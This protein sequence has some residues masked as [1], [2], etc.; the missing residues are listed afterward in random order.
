LEDLWQFNEECVARA[1]AA[2]ELPIITGIGHE[3]DTSI[4]DLV[5]DYH[6]HTPTE[7]ASIAVRHWLR[8]TELIGAGSMRL[9]GA[10]RSVL[11]EARQRLVSIERHEVFRRPTHRIESYRQFMDDRER[12]LDAALADRLR[13]A[14][15]RIE[16]MRARLAGCHPKHRLALNAQRLTD[17]ERRLNLALSS[18][19]QKQATHLNAVDAQLRAISPVAVLGRGY[20]ITTLKRDG[21]IVRSAMAIKA[22][23]RLVTRLS[24]GTLESITQDSKQGVLFE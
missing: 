11:S 2:S 6:A 20:S 4:A 24:D 12:A 22:G 10:V 16:R 18:S 14:T 23:E 21:S 5:A 8:A 19:L 3:I 1:I 17:V 13:V 7:A 15:V 9:K